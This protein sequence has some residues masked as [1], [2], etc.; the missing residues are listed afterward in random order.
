MQKESSKPRLHSR[1]TPL[2]MSLP[3]IT[4][5]ATFLLRAPTEFASLRSHPC[6]RP[7][8]T[9]AER[10]QP[11]PSWP[12]PCFRRNHTGG[13]RHRLLP[14]SCQEGTKILHSGLGPG[15]YLSPRPGVESLRRGGQITRQ[16]RRFL[17]RAGQ[18]SYLH[19][20]QGWRIFA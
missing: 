13:R 9:K 7:S 20:P 12:S 19:F 10:W 16:Q 4:R 15:G 11:Q 2:T 14:V 17:K 5:R 8:Q 1:Q 18:S 3:T 6:S